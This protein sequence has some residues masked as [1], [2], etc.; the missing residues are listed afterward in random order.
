MRPILQV[1]KED[2]T[3][4]EAGY[5][6]GERSLEPHSGFSV[7]AALTLGTPMLLLIY[8]FGRIPLERNTTSI[9]ILINLPQMRLSGISVVGAN[10]FNSTGELLHLE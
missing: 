2:G 7:D 5:R 3:G 9:Q 6:A 10:N 4:P 8:S 1:G